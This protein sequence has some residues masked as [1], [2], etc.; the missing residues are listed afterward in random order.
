MTDEL[1]KMYPAYLEEMKRLADMGWDGNIDKNHVRA[2]EVLCDTLRALGM[3]S[4]VD[5]YEKV[6]KW[7][8]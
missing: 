6:C 3:D 7:Y 5:E 2:D 8:A 1:E 4:L